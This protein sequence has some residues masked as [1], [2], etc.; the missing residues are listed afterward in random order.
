MEN[1][2]GFRK[3]IDRALEWI[4]AIEKHLGI[5]KKIGDRVSSGIAVTWIGQSRHYSVDKHDETDRPPLDLGGA[6]FHARRSSA[7]KFR[8]VATF[9]GLS[10]IGL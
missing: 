10:A 3:E 4:A 1:L 5:E 6:V 9:V 8:A 7:R 2:I